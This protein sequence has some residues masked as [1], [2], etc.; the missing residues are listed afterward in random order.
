METPES[1]E[2]PI[3]A[4]NSPIFA[5]EPP[6]NH[7]QQHQQQPTL[8]RVPPAAEDGD[9]PKRHACR[10]CHAV[11]VRCLQLPPN[12]GT[13]CARC[14]RIGQPC[15]E[16]VQGIRGRR[17][18]SI[19]S[20]KTTRDESPQHST[21][22]P[23]YSSAPEGA[24]PW[25]DRS[26]SSSSSA[27]PSP[28]TSNPLR[29]FPP[30][31]G[32]PHAPSPLLALA[33]TCSSDLNSSL[34]AAGEQSSSASNHSV[35]STTPL[36]S[37][38]P[39]PP[40][41]E[42]AG[43]LSFAET[44]E[45]RAAVARKR[46]PPP[47]VAPRP[48]YP[49]PVDMHILGMFEADQLFANFHQHLNIHIKILD[50][51]LHTAMY[52]RTASTVLFTAILAASAK[53]FRRDLYS[54]LLS[55]AQQ[56]VGRAM[57]ETLSCVEVI[58]A[59]C[60]LVYWKEP[61]DTSAWMRVGWVTRLGYQLRLHALRETPLPSDNELEA[62][63]IMDRERTWLT[64][65]C[66]DSSYRLNGDY[67]EP[68]PLP[69]RE[70]ELV[71]RWLEDSKLL[72]N[73]EDLYTGASLEVSRI[74]RLTAVLEKSDSAAARET[75]SSHIS[76]LLKALFNKY[77]HPDCDPA[78]ALAG[79]GA[80]YKVRLTFDSITVGFARANL[81]ASNFSDPALIAEFGSRVSDL[82]A[83]VEITAKNDGFLDRLQDVTAVN[84]FS[85]GEFLVKLFGIVGPGSMQNCIVSWLTSIYNTCNK[86]NTEDG[87]P[88]FVA[89]FYRLLLQH[90]ATSS[91][92]P[93]TR[94]SSPNGMEAD[95]RSLH[96]NVQIRID[97]LQPLDQDFKFSLPGGDPSDGN[98]ISGCHGRNLG[99]AGHF[100]TAS[101]T[102]L[103]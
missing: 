36:T 15:E 90:L 68:T 51:Y 10:G 54:N 48:Q 83:T 39:A 20:R 1:S 103:N 60:I 14:L 91:S 53:F 69:I 23:S 2:R 13:G 94:A 45:A 35:K 37:H 6:T 67:S 95:G 57:I 58:Q 25:L 17:A 97:E 49:D 100:A 24:Q 71:D 33:Q 55:H 70:I 31:F 76:E 8:S 12:Q 11:K 73:W 34:R 66:F 64:L 4:N 52:T 47:R 19:Q 28:S 43:G 59:I 75:L 27:V 30:S 86:C 98:F 96:S 77:F 78:R 101:P 32:T 87:S 93:S 56:L 84:L 92:R 81:V 80:Y 99:M 42:S 79:S 29:Q 65:V 62:R 85:L 82:V 9:E 50:R 63:K 26:V 44:A 102:R 74:I 89:I 22:G 5:A 18:G 16:R 61:H 21:P 38:P 3:Q 72:G 7:H 41:H 88:T 46:Q 40:P